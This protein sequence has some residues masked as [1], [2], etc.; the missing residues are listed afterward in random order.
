[1]AKSF[2][3]ILSVI[4][5]TTSSNMIMSTL[6]T[7]WLLVYPTVSSG[8]SFEGYT[9]PVTYQ[10][11]HCGSQSQCVQPSKGM[12]VGCYP[13][14]ALFRTTLQCLYNQT[15]VYPIA[16]TNI[17]QSINISKTRSTRFLLSITVESIINQL[18]LEKITYEMSD[19]NY[20]HECSPISC[21][22]SYID[23]TNFI[24]GITSLAAL[25]A[26]LVIICE[27]ISNIIIHL[28]PINTQNN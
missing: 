11:C 3:N 1:M 8:T 28:Y 16:L 6:S 21:T 24:H 10:Q 14:E 17:F 13:L 25:Y 4:R 19:E 23:Y 15:C 18:M 7:N 26:G 9:I 2:L 27:L 22:Y 12:L 20:F 5:E